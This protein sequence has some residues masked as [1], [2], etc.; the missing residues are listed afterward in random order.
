MLTRRH[1]NFYHVQSEHMHAESPELLLSSFFLHKQEKSMSSKSDV[2]VGHR[3]NLFV[4]IILTCASES[5]V[6]LS[7]TIFRIDL[8][9]LGQ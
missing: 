5:R 1:I 8:M 7:F 9:S 2:P 6:Y 4:L 3:D